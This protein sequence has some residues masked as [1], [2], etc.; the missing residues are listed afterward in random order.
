MEGFAE[1]YCHPSYK[2]IGQRRFVTNVQ[3]WNISNFPGGI[4]FSF[5]DCGPGMAL[6]VLLTVFRKDGI[7]EYY[8]MD[9]YHNGHFGDNWQKWQTHQLPLFPY[10]GL[11]GHAENIKFSYIIHKD[12]RSIPS[13]Y[14]YKFASIHDFHKGRVENSDFHDSYFKIPNPYRTFEV[15]RTEVQDA[16]DRINTLYGDLPVRP[17]F[18]RGNT[19]NTDHPIHEIHKH[20]D[21]VIERKKADPEGRHYIQMA[22]FDF[23]NYHVAQHLIHAVQAGVE[24][25][26]IADWPAVSSLNVTENI[27]KMRR[28]GIPIYGIVRN[29]PCDPTEGIASMHTKIIIFDG[30]IVHSSSYNLHFH[31]WGG[32]WE[33][34]LVYYSPDFVTVYS[35]IYH[36]LRG[37]VVQRLSVTP[38]QRYNLYYSFGSYY[39]PFRD[40][41]RAQ[42]A[43][44][45]EIN[46]AK[47]TI[48]VSMFDIGY[49]TGV[50]SYDNH[51]TDVI[52]A[53][54]NARNRGVRVKIILNGMIC[55][56]GELPQSWDTAKWRPLKEPVKRLK[57]N[58]ME[59]VFVYYWE[60]IYSPLHHKFAVFDNYTVITESCNWYVASLYS[61]EVLSVVRDERLAREFTDEA[62]KICQSFRLGYD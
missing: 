6:K 7:C 38:E 37:G 55:H 12:G 19:W 32:N 50:S 11:H 3:G 15:E 53:L 28:A 30:E 56:T 10:E 51:E 44:V 43:I 5:C 57:D 2:W 58:W 61:D 18:T 22:I 54:I 31:L 47:H 24:V 23:D 62:N 8:L 33:N 60:S 21:W 46:N 52:A 26:C 25:E 14:E 1:E 59:L 34:G 17:F 48:I 39:T 42:D 45:T 29:T 49:I 20:I 16:L 9:A 4:G 41:Y 40:Y 27:A 35:N 13:Y 36:A